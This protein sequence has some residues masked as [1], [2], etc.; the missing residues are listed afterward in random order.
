MPP[1]RKSDPSRLASLLVGAAVVAL[2]LW[3]TAK[4]PRARRVVAT[5]PP[6]PLAPDGLS[7]EANAAQTDAQAEP[8]SPPLAGDGGGLSADAPRAIRIGVVL[9]HFAGAEGAPT[10]ARTRVEAAARAERLAEL[11]RTDFHRAVQ[12]GDPGSQD[13][14]GLISRGILAEAT[15][16]RLFTL[17][18]GSTSGVIETPRGFWIA[19]RI[20]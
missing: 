2:A 14:V 11:A 18:P 9:V 13:D 16:L 3:M 15:E 19:R 6:A 7:V 5:S 17:P 1:G 8:P 20:E 12:E 10:N 4:A